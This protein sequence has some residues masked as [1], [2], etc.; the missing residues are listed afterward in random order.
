MSCA[1]GGQ[2]RALDHLELEFSDD[3]EQACGHWE[4]NLGPWQEQQVSLTTT[5]SLQPLP[6]AVSSPLLEAV[7]SEKKKV[8]GREKSKRRELLRHEGLR[9]TG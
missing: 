3:C 9:Q 1:P 6:N 7:T 2:K 4:L 8:K 5:P